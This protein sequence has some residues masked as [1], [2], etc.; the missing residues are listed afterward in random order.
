MSSTS[1]IVLP[2]G[3]KKREQ[4][5]KVTTSLKVSFQCVTAPPSTAIVGETEWDVGVLYLVPWQATLGN[6]MCRQEPLS[7]AWG[8]P[9]Q[10]GRRLTDRS[11]SRERNQAPA[12]SWTVNAPCAMCSFYLGN[13]NATILFLRLMSDGIVV[14]RTVIVHQLSVALR[15]TCLNTRKVSICCSSKQVL[16]CRYTPSLSFDGNSSPWC[17]GTDPGRYPWR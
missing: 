11:K 6:I 1:F 12:N 5:T 7:P 8:G 15:Y 2:D 4:N 13:F 3:K 16:G 14:P 9:L 17:Q 10:Q